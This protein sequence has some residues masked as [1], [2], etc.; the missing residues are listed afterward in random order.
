VTLSHLDDEG[1]AHMVDVSGKDVTDRV[2]TATGRVRCSDAVLRAL[3]EGTNSKGDVV[4]TARLAGIMA[5]KRT[6]ELIPLCH[7]LPL[8]SVEVTVDVDEEAG[9]VQ[10]SATVR[11]T[12]RTGVEMEALTAVTVAAL[13]VIDMA[14]AVDPWM[15]IDDVSLL[16]KEG[17]R[18]GVR[19]R[20]SDGR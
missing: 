2:A 17:G 6:A 4:A 16:H 9:C 7:P 5:A 8:T 12:A 15:R 13:T 18:S 10:L 14:K 11:C 3:R 1:A 19:H 20:P